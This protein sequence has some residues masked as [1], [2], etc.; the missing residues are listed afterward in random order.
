MNYESLKNQIPPSQSDLLLQSWGFD[1]MNEYFSIATLL[2]RNNAPVIEL[3]TGTGRMCAILSCIYPFIISGDIS[4][5]DLP[6]TLQRIPLLVLDRVHFLQLNMEKL[7]FRSGSID[8]IMCINTI[9]EVDHPQACMKEMIRTM[10]P[11]GTLVIG[12]FNKTGF[13]VMQKIQEIV[14]HTNHSEGFI[15]MDEVELLLSSSF[16]TVRSVATP[17]NITYVS[18]DKR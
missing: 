9:H 5:T 12:D 16:S 18:S 14:Y 11:N 17:L 3:A 6:R 7:P 8:S 10:S 1:L 15:T 4:L 2:P 13:S